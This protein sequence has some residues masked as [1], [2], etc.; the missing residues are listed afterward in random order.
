MSNNSKTILLVEDEA[1]IAILHKRSLSKYGFD[2]ITAD[3]GEKAEQQYEF[4]IISK[5]GTDKWVHLYGTSVIY[6]NNSAGLISVID[7]DG[8]NNK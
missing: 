1:I 2:V 4:K 7:T 3:T 6:R 8:I 5:N